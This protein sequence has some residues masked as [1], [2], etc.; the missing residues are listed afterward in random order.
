MDFIY[1][2]TTQPMI[3]RSLD[4][5]SCEKL[6]GSGGIINWFRCKKINPRPSDASVLNRSF[7]FKTRTRLQT[8]LLG[9]PDMF[10][11]VANVS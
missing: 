6:L 4:Q 2:Y 11:V 8:E 5:L 7:T 3:D 10:I 1:S 9:T